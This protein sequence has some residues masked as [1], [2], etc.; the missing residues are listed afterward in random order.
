MEKTSLKYS[1]T[2]EGTFGLDFGSIKYLDQLQA[3]N[4]ISSVER[5]KINKIISYSIILFEKAKNLNDTKF[6]DYVVRKIYE[7]VNG[8]IEDNKFENI[9][10]KSLLHNFL[11]T[12]KKTLNEIRTIGKR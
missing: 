10:I 7:D 3:E 9:L 8:K 5:K 11:T 12:Y 1:A 2:L 4:K 6:K